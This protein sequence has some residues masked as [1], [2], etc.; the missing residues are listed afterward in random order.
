MSQFGPCPTPTPTPTPTLT[1]TP[2]P[3]STPVPPT[4]TPT[5]TATPVPPT[6]TPTPTPTVSDITLNLNS[7]TTSI[8]D[9]RFQYTRTN[10]TNAT[11][12]LSDTDG[13]IPESLT[14]TIANAKPSTTATA[15]VNKYSSGTTLEIG[16]GTVVPNV[17]LIVNINGTD[18]YNQTLD[19]GPLTLNHSFTYNSGDV[20]IV[21][22]NITS[23]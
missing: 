23:I 19:N 1:P 16:A 8:G 13:S 9:V 3:T 18:V 22:G 10:N 2:T 6:P 20:V 5:P 15:I 17:N 12:T 14:T 7:D 11:V 21:T 4:P